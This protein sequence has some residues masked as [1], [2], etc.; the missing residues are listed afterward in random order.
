MDGCGREVSVI[1][2]RQ[3][4]YFICVVF[5]GHRYPSR[6]AE[7]SSEGDVPIRR[8]EMVGRLDEGQRVAAESIDP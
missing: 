3:R 7:L 8:R 5:F 2:Y 6:P 1:E 4:I